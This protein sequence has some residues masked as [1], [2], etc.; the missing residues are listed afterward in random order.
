MY[1]LFEAG[2]AILHGA[3]ISD[4]TMSDLVEV[5]VLALLFGVIGGVLAGIKF[6]K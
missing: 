5:M 2:N 3:L 6:S 4:D 1:G